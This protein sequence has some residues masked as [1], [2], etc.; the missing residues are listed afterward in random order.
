VFTSLDLHN[1]NVFRRTAQ[2]LQRSAAQ[3][4]AQ[5]ERR[6]K[7]RSHYAQYCAAAAAQ[8]GATLRMQFCAALRT[9]VYI[10]IMQI[11]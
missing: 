2:L 3:Y 9:F 5:C 6:L 1:V 10:Y 8:Y 4:C 7:P 11:K